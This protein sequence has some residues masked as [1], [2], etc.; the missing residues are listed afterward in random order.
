MSDEWRLPGS[1]V[2][3]LACGGLSLLAN[4][5]GILSVGAKQKK[6]KP[7]EFLLCTLAAT[8]MLTVAVPIAT[9]AVVQLRRQHPDYEWNE[10]LCKVFVST[11]YTLTLATC[12]SVTSLSYHRMWMVLWPVNYRLSNAK[13]QAVHTVMGIWMVSFTLSAL[14][15]VGWHDTRERF[16]AHGCRFIVAE[17]GLGFGVCFVLLVGGSVAM[18]VGCTAVAL[19]QTLAVWAGRR[20]DGRAFTVPTIVVEDAQGKRRSSIDGSEPAKTSLQITGLVATIVV[21]YDCLVGFPVLVVSFSSLRADAS[22]PWMALSVLWCSVTQTLLLPVFLW[23]C[24]RYR[25]DVKAVWEKCMALMA[26]NEDSD[27]EPS[28]EGGA[29]PDLVLERSLDCGYRGDFVPLDRTGPAHAALLP[30]RRGRVGR[31]AA[32]RF[33]APLGLRRGPGRPGAAGAARPARRPPRQPAGLLRGRAP[34]P[35]APPLGREPALA[36]APGLGRRPAPRARLAPRQP[37][38]PAPPPRAWRPLR[39]GVAAARRLRLDRLRARAARPAPP[40]RPAGALP[41]RRPPDPRQRGARLAAG[42]LRWR[43]GRA[44]ESRA[45]PGWSCARQ[46]PAQRPERVV[47]GARGLARGGRRRQH[48]QLPELAVRVVGLRHAALGLFGLRVLGPTAR[49]GRRAGGAARGAPKHQ[50]FRHRAQPSATLSRGQGRGSLSLSV[51]RLLPGCPGKKDGLAEHLLPGRTGLGGEQ[52]RACLPIWVKA[53]SGRPAAPT[54]SW[55]RWAGV[56]MQR[57]SKHRGLQSPESSLSRSPCF[58]PI[59]PQFPHL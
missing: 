8:H 44:A 33:P 6:W 48:Q 1:A 34:V 54:Q 32:A 16:Y 13:K 53:G 11:F 10:G 58:C 47:G 55:G 51:F 29:P 3:W 2:G 45:A 12:F 14:P 57:V 50:R 21:I 24:D 4:A 40:A 20:A 25:A 15:A 39:L 7:L 27:D 26:N 28:L 36:A 23:A 30:R 49:L 9:Y 42:A 56:G 5:W 46:A 59:L 31:R 41:S 17:I 19:F 22:A 18:G 38:Q 43:R 52:C 37:G 35:P